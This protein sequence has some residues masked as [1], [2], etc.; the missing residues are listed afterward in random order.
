MDM[1][2]QIS[3]DLSGDINQILIQIQQARAAIE[4]ASYSLQEQK[5]IHNAAKTLRKSMQKQE[6]FKRVKTL[7]DVL[8]NFDKFTEQGFNRS[9]IL[10]G[11]SGK[12]LLQAHINLQNSSDAL[13]QQAQEERLKQALL[14]GY[15]LIMGIRQ[16]VGFDKI[17]YGIIY[18]GINGSGS[19]QLLMGTMDIESLITQGHLN[20]SLSIVLNQTGAQINEILNSSSQ[21]QSD[22]NYIDLLARGQNAQT[23]DILNQIK[24][25]ITTMKTLKDKR[26]YYSYGQLT[27]ALI[28]LEG[29]ELSVDNI[30]NALIQGQNT[31]SFEKMGDFRLSLAEEEMDIQAKTFASQ[32]VRDDEIKTIRITSL[33]N[34]VRVL[35][36]LELAFNASAGGSIIE[37]IKAQFQQSKT[38]GG[39]NP[40][41]TIEEDIKREIDKILS[42]YFK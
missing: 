25:K 42:Q 6:E 39:K 24:D 28:D 11:A 31:T 5:R 15:K 14:R 41:L 7:Q 19:Q 17:N 34:I 37:N 8:E 29:K 22:R 21:Q 2:A 23:W 16:A 26:V 18:T 27:E 20:S 33:S 1:A 35:N 9:K 4:E 10:K 32:G 38:S 13:I 12:E 40:M 30:F 3:A 36:N